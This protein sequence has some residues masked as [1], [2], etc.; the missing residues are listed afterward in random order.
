LSL[1]LVWTRTCGSYAAL[2]VILGMTASNI[3][4]WLHFSKWV[5]LL[6]LFWIDTAKIQ[7]PTLHMI[8]VFK[9][10]FRWKPIIT[11]LLGCLRWS[12]NRN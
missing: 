4:K 5:L 2:Q 12:K 1:V 6:A 11:S 7:M 8:R 10:L 3:L 9:R